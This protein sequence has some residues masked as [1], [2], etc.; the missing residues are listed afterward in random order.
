MVYLDDVGLSGGA[1][2][3]RFIHSSQSTG[4]TSC[5]APPLTLE[6]IYEVV[7]RANNWKDFTDWLAPS[8]FEPDAILREQDSDKEACLKA[9]IEGFLNEGGWREPS[10]R[11]VI[12]ALYKAG[13]NH[14]AHNIITYAEPLKG[15]C[16]R[17][18]VQLCVCVC[19]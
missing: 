17:V 10:W 14:I 4:F 16:V 18:C 13:E 11:A 12:R 2:H 15:V 1:I 5:Q 7:K 9:F 6:S 3:L 8:F 19:E